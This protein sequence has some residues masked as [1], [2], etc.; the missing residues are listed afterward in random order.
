MYILDTNVISEL[1]KIRVGTANPNVAAWAKSVQFSTLFV[2]T[3][4]IMEIEI[5]VLSLERKDATQGHLL[6]SWLE[7]IVLPKFSGRILPVDTDVARQCARLHV[8]NRRNER[9]AV[10]AATGLVYG[11]PIVT[12]N[13]ADFMDTGVTILNPWDKP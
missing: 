1:R 4:S 5:G 8:P 7:N 2:S 12:R 3:I 13:V 9:D 6:R 10:I 11:M